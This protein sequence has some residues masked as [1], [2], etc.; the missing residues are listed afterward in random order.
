M[1]GSRIYLNIE[2]VN[3]YISRW[4]K[5]NLYLYFK[6]NTT[7]YMYTVYHIITKLKT[8]IITVYINGSIYDVIYICLLCLQLAT[9]ICWQY[10]NHARY[11]LC[12]WDHCQFERGA[13]DMKGFHVKNADDIASKVMDVYINKRSYGV[14]LN[15]N[16]FDVKKGSFMEISEYH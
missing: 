2:T 16:I 14:R 11:V 15:F 7:L 8:I 10:K 4:Y 1:Y 13:F 12:Q 5:L 3:K 9:C 6:L